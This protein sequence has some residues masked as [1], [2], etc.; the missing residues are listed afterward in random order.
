[1][2][3]KIAFQELSVFALT[4]L[5]QIPTPKVVDLNG[6]ALLP[7]PGYQPLG[8]HY[9]VGNADGVDAYI[10]KRT[11]NLSG[12]WFS[13]ISNPNNLNLYDICYSPT[14]AYIVAV[15][16][17]SGAGGDA[18]IIYTSDWITGSPFAASNHVSNPKNF[19]LNGVCWAV[20]LGLFVAVG[21]PDGGDAYLITASNPNTWTERATPRN[22]TLYGVCF[23]FERKLLV[24]VGYRAG[25]PN[26]PWVIYSADGVNW[27]EAT[28]PADATGILY[29]VRWHKWLKM[30]FAVNS[31]GPGLYSYDGVNW[32]KASW[33][34]GTQQTDETTTV[35]EMYGLCSENPNMF[36]A[37]GESPAG[38]T[39]PIVAW[40]FDG[41]NWDFNNRLFAVGQDMKAIAVET[42]TGAFIIVGAGSISSG[43]YIS[44]PVQVGYFR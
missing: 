2:I 26:I 23:A 8:I 14:S 21:S 27:S 33:R 10:L 41:I 44:L 7:S 17:A 31:N 20:S 36:V 24:A 34:K 40:S 19:D 29:K 43:Y 18:Y 3:K 4:N 42:W 25:T 28:V 16:A 32:Y 9:A 15:G 35:L 13:E 37:V 5:F 39:G 30:F 6:V 38:G 11:C 22:E 1:M 12:T